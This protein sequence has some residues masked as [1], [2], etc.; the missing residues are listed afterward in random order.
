[1]DTFWEKNHVESNEYWLSSTNSA[2]YILDIHG[3]DKNISGKTILDIGIGVGNLCRYLHSKR[4]KMNACDIS[5]SALDKVKSFAN[6]YHTSEL[7]RVEPV[8]LAI[9]NLVFQHCNDAEI[10]RII[11]DIN[12]KDDGIFSFQFAFLREDEIPNDN[13]KRLISNGTHHFRDINTIIKI[14]NTANKKIV[15]ISKPIHY[16]GSENFS[17]HIVKISN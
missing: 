2:E 12:L 8:D 15:D 6:T 13:V 9:S 10:A 4:N 11:K 3:I 16:Y 14:V 5:H 1:M 17:W 7:N